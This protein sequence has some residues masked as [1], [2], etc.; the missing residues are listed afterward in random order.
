M[1]IQEEELEVAEISRELMEIEADLKELEEDFG[2][3]G[4]TGSDD[5]QESSSEIE[6]L[7]RMVE[8]TD[9]EFSVP[10]STSEITVLDIAD[11]DL[12][13]EEMQEGIWDVVKSAAGA[14]T[15]TI[16]GIPGAGFIR[17]QIKKR[18]GR[19]ISKLIKLV[20][21]YKRLAV[22]VPKVTAAVAAFKA[23]RYG[24]ALKLGFSAYRCIK[25]RL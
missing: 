1:T 13:E 9:F 22:C 4:L 5:E 14:V 21:K 2:D 8:G 20:K 25:A 23:G 24:T 16:S 17:R 12:S 15:S 19:L 10:E 6:S 3:I 7:N 11:A 18:A